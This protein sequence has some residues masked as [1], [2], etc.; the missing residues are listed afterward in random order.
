MRS[1]L[2]S[3]LLLLLFTSA[4]AA[5][6]G[7]RTVLYAPGPLREPL[8]DALAIELRPRL[9]AVGSDEI[10]LV[11][12]V[13]TTRVRVRDVRAG[14][15]VQAPI[16][17][18]SDPR[19]LALIVA[20]LA[21]EARHGPPPVVAQPTSELASPAIEA[22]PAVADA[23]E[24]EA[25]Q[26]PPRQTWRRGVGVYGGVGV[27]G[28]YAW[29]PPRNDSLGGT[30]R[31]LVGLRLVEELRLGVMIEAGVHTQ[32]AADGTATFVHPDFYFALEPTGTVPL[33]PVSLHAAPRGGIYV[34]EHTYEAPR[35]DPRGFP[36]GFDRTDH[37]GVGFSV[38]GFA[39][40]SIRATDGVDVWLR[41]DFDAIIPDTLDGPQIPEVS[42]AE[43]L[44]G[45]LSAM[46]VFE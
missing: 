11:V 37:F 15:T 18:G 21:S 20:S 3:L 26:A 46:V 12:F 13:E 38:G 40:L 34:S 44:R 17:P 35:F 14:V 25:A 4:A 33:G 28:T 31:G 29:E 32:E 24:P 9:V 43:I 2:G 27:G 5:Q 23:A 41:L 7:P 1:C 8:S 45:A 16:Q 42:R 10:D 30:L 6:G 39:A 19:T 36:A 22:R